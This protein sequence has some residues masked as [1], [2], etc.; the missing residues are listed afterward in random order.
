MRGGGGGGRRRRR[1]ARRGGGRRS[2]LGQFPDGLQVVGER[3]PGG[4]LRFADVDDELLA[5]LAL[6]PD[7]GVVEVLAG[8]VELKDQRGL[9][10]HVHHFG[11][12]A[13][14]VVLLVYLQY[15]VQ[16]YPV[17]ENCHAARAGG[18]G[19]GGEKKTCT[20]S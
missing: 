3:G 2:F 7:A 18:G 12:G 17:R 20:I 14:V 13:L 19:G 4:A 15:V 9:V 10:V 11:L 1:R 8:A 16:A 5:G 6:Q